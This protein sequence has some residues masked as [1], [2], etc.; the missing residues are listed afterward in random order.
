MASQIPDGPWTLGQGECDGKPMLMRLNTGASPFVGD[1]RYGQRLD[2]A[3]PHRAPNPAGLPQPAEA[4]EIGKLED[5]LV[6]AL[7]SG[8]A[9]AFVLAVTTGKCSYLKLNNNAV[10]VFLTA[11]SGGTQTEVISN[12]NFGTDYS[13][14]VTMTKGT[15]SA[16][17]VDSLG[18]DPRGIPMVNTQSTTFTITKAGE[19]KTVVVGAYGRVAW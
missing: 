13:V 11:C 16:L 14:T 1:P 15:G 9:G 17:A 19:S 10:T 12:R 8:G 3:I 7:T 4:L 18:F 6:A 2:V 5:Q